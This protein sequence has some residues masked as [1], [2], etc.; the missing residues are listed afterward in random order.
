MI[1]ALTWKIGA[2]ILGGLLLTVG[3]AGLVDNIKNRATIS[4]LRA[5]NKALGDQL[6]TANSNIGICHAS[7]SNLDASVK[8]QNSDIRG[9]FEASK[10]SSDRAAAAAQAAAAA[11]KAAR[12]TADQILALPRPSPELAC[13][14]AERLLRGLP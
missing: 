8:A 7:V 5:S 11:S 12:V 1:A 6:N 14:E 10:A 4:E 2:L 3:V 9:F 13:V